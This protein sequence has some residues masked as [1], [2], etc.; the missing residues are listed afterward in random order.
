MD[1]N[2]T[3]HTI[4]EENDNNFKIM[5]EN[6]FL[7]NLIY[8]K[9]IDPNKINVTV[10]INTNVPMPKRILHSIIRNKLNFLRV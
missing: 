6:D 3:R 8:I 1:T 4:Y 10:D 2:I 9:R 5:Y 7:Q